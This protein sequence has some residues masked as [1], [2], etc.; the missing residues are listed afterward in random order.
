LRAEG[1]SL[2]KGSETLEWPAIGKKKELRD[3]HGPVTHY[4]RITGNVKA[5]KMGEEGARKLLKATTRNCL[6]KKG[7]S[8]TGTTYESLVIVNNGYL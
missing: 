4:Q 2:S 8:V 5:E 1:G 7:V 3:L 6:G